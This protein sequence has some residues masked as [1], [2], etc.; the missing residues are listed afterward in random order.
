M[1]MAGLYVVVSPIKTLFQ[2][3]GFCYGLAQK[4]SCSLVLNLQHVQ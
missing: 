1:K 3:K 2:G 4:K